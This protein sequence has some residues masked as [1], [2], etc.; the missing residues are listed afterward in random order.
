MKAQLN[1]SQIKTIII[2]ISKE[3]TKIGNNTLR[4]IFEIILLLLT[5]EKKL[6][7]TETSE[8]VQTL[9]N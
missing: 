8:K 9:W 5:L 1:N 3:M 6:G 7:M 2:Q 4:P